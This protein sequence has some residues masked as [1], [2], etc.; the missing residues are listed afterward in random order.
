MKWQPKDVIA[1]V[2]ICG[3]FTLLA[4]GLDSFVG[5]TLIAIVGGYFGIDL[6]P[7][8]KLGRKQGAKKEE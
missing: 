7:A 2:V 8:I 5:W 4:M 6:T 1:L 3:A